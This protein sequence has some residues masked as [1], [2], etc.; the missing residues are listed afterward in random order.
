M[1]FFLLLLFNINWNFNN[2]KFYHLRNHIFNNIIFR[3][4][5]IYFLSVSNYQSFQKFYYESII[6][7]LLLL[8]Y[9]ISKSKVFFK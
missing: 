3:L 4:N 9:G 6:I 1:S 7:N 5:K 2:N 8:L